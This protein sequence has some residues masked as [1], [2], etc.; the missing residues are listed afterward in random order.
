MML[1]PQKTDVFE[2]EEKFNDGWSFSF[3]PGMK[4]R[5]SKVKGNDVTIKIISPIEECEKAIEEFGKAIAK[6]YQKDIATFDKIIKI[7][8]DEADKFVI[9]DKHYRNSGSKLNRT[10]NTGYYNIPKEHRASPGRDRD[11][12]ILTYFYKH[13]DGKTI[14]YS[15]QKNK[16]E[17]FSRLCYE[18]MRE[19]DKL[20]LKQYM[21]M[22]DKTKKSLY[23]MICESM[24]ISTKKFNM[25]KFKKI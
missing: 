4:F 14:I 8:E 19:G 6:N 5:I 24:E 11:D 23:K 7:W 10:I 2:F 25:A 18:M 20:K 3:F 9:D 16:N 13:I 22:S 15:Y 17:W 1:I 12:S 21:E